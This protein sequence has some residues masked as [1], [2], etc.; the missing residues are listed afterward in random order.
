MLSPEEFLSNNKS[1]RHFELDVLK[2][3]SSAKFQKA[4]SQQSNIKKLLYI[5]QN[6]LTRLRLI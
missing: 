3:F 5:T 4:S 1:L 2:H 6:F